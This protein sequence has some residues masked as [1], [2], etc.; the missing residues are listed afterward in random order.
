MG[1]TID[2]REAPNTAPIIISEVKA[3]TTIVFNAAA[4][5]NNLGLAYSLRM[6]IDA[7]QIY[8]NNVGAGFAS[9]ALYMDYVKT[10][11]EGLGYGI[12]IDGLNMEITDIAGN[13]ASTNTKVSIIESR[14][15]NANIF[16]NNLTSSPA[17]SGGVT[18]ESTF[19]TIQ[20]N[21]P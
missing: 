2:L 18:A 7:T 11:L 13:G 16:T 3:S 19:Y 9:N 10:T 1:Q 14:D 6:F 4:F 5:P 12:V 20:L 8:S 17:F 21:K 15:E